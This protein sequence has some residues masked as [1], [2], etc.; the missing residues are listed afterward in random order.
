MLEILQKKKKNTKKNDDDKKTN[1]QIDIILDVPGCTFSGLICLKVKGRQ[2]RASRE[3][4][5]G[6]RGYTW[7]KCTALD[8]QSSD[9]P[10]NIEENV[11]WSHKFIF[12]SDF[13]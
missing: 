1:K 10:S 2:R 6:G 11:C 7:K 3:M 9:D 4:G 13:L 5:G 8:T 12:Q